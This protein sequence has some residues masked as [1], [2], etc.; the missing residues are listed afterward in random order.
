MRFRALVLGTTGF[1]LVAATIVTATVAIEWFGAPKD[2]IQVPALDLQSQEKAGD[3]VPETNQT[4]GAPLAAG[5]MHAPGAIQTFLDTYCI[6]CH[7]AEKQKGDRR[8]DRLNLPVSKVDTLILLQDIVDQLN[9]G[10]MPPRKAKQPGA[11][12]TRAAIA[13]LT[14]TI[15]DA[16]TK[17]A[18]AGGQTVLR[19]LNRREYLKTVGDLF[20]LN[21][22]MF[23]P[24]TAF[25]RDETVAHMDNIGSALK[26]SGYLLAQYLDA[27]D[28]IVEKAFA[29]KERPREQSWKFAGNFVQQQELRSH[30]PVFQFRYLCLYETT[31]SDKHEGA[32]GPLLEFAKGVPADGYYEIKVRAEAKHRKNPYD[33]KLFAMDPEMP[34]RLGVVPGNQKAGALHET[35]PIEPLLG[36]VVLKDE[37]LEWYT[38]K[39]WLDAGHT[40]RFIFPNGMISVRNAYGRIFRQYNA[41]FPAEVRKA[42][43]GIVNDRI[44]V[45]KY[46]Q[47]PHIRIHE[48][49]IRGPLIEQWPPPSQTVVLGDQ[50]FD[51]GRTRAILA[52]F[53]SRAYRRPAS[54]AEVDRLMAVVE[55]RRQ[56]GKEPL[57]ALKA[58]L[59]AVLCSPA[60]LYLADPDEKQGP[61]ATRDRALTPHALAA[62]L[63]YFLWSTTPDAELTNLAQTGELLKPEVLA[64]QTRRLLA[65]P[66]SDA[67]VTGLLDSWLN[68]RSFGDMPPDRAAFPLYYAHDLQTAMRRETQLFTRHLLD[69]NESIVRFLDADYSF[70]NRQLAQHYGMADAVAAA[71]GH[72]FRRVKL[73]DPNRGGLLGQGSVLTVS[74][75]GV[76]TSPV[77]RGVWLL[78]NILGTPPA[79]PPDNVPPIDPDI[80]GAKSIRDILI[81]HRNNA[82]CFECHRKIDP[83]GF[84]LENFDPIGSW[85][86]RYPKGQPIDPAG[87]LPGGQSF[88][89]VAEL[90]KILV[91]RK[92]QFAQMLTEKILSYGCGRRIEALDRPL[93]IRI[94][95][96]L[97]KN[98]YGFRLLIEQVVLSE[99]FRSK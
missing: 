7:G 80:R 8:F 53:A 87:E 81:K 25:P 64:A 12:E 35:Q 48:V 14:R 51:A 3:S 32:Y 19:R 21:M 78:E 66:R 94:V 82:T 6:Q 96:E 60:F 92:D 65:S 44:M 52:T 26:T 30:G 31:A 73:T 34:F 47:L 33:P 95:D 9:L 29:A 54:A 84:A 5:S 15:A 86:T 72:V 23:D 28:Q 61:A 56:D 13:E 1:V 16:R 11:H 75:N 4:P 37:Q 42:K 97:K 27:A 98:E 91:E 83:L 24:T 17:F 62:R 40:P 18:S 39:V 70:L 89:D 85:R 55:R 45:Q 67:L 99:T 10:E 68:L 74:A 50:P 93:V 2:P 22:T 90:K 41:L 71:D 49:N 46:G 43:G 77:T 63:S 88:K 79:P 38:F 58:A 76:E 57:E 20:A 36:E 69:A 59:K